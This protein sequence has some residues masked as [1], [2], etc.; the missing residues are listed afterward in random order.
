L[1]TYKVNSKHRKDISVT[2]QT[3]TAYRADWQS[4]FW[5]I[6]QKND[7]QRSAEFSCLS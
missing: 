3:T 1:V 2:A 7:N 5:S 4:T 6:K